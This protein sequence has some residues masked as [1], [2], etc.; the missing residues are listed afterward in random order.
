[1]C[2]R[3]RADTLAEMEAGTLGDTLVDVEVEAL[4]DAL[5][6]RLAEVEAEILGDTLAD[7]EVEALVDTL[8]DTVGEVEAESLL[9]S[10]GLRV[11][12]F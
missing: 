7:V 2:I 6:E 8:P 12:A 9:T 3:D 1:M 10:V 4:V 11:L 5:A